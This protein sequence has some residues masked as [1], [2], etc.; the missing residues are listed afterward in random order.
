MTEKKLK[1]YC[2]TSFWSYLNGRPKTVATVT[3]AG[4]NC[5]VIITPM[6]FLE[7]KEEFGL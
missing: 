2:E 4:F 7:R 6:D 1:V 3:K 5:P